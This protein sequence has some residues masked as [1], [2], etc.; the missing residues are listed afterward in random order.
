MASLH[1]ETEG[2]KAAARHHDHLRESRHAA[3]EAQHDVDELFCKQARAQSE[4]LFKER[5][6]KKT[7]ADA[8]FQTG[9]KDDGY[10][11]M[12]EVK[13]L[14]AA[15]HD[16]THAAAKKIFGMKNARV[17]TFEV[18]LH[19]LEVDEAVGFVKQRVERDV[20]EG[21]SKFPA[22]V[23]VYGAGHHSAGGKQLLKPA[24]L[25]ALKER[26]QGQLVETREDWDATT[27]KPNPGCVSVQYAGG[28]FDAL[29]GQRKPSDTEVH[30][31]SAFL[32]TGYRGYIRQ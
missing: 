29:L 30:F 3:E 17:G 31:V 6:A 23:I 10:K 13:Q 19:G 7:L 11:L 15:A 16:A 18:D 9:N 1:F 25:K 8:A 22:V 4:S 14:T 26:P 12:A 20:A 24:V 2:E 5:D 21:A 28:S 27:G 32:L